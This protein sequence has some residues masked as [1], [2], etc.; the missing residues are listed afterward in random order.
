MSDVEVPV[1][2]KELLRS[3]LR[4]RAGDATRHTRYLSEKTA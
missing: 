3:T 4:A 2:K 1:S